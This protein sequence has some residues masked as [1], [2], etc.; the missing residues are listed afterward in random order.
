MPIKYLKDLNEIIAE[1]N[2]VDSIEDED[3]AIIANKVLEEFED[4]KR[5]RAEWDDKN[6]EALE[7]AKLVERPK[8]FPFENSA[9]VKYPLLT[10][11]A[12]QFA[13]RTYPEIIR[14]GRAIEY[15]VVGGDPQGDKAARAKRL[16]DHDNYQLLIASNR[17][18][19]ETD[20]LLH[21]LPIYGT[22]FRKTYFDP[23]DKTN[24]SELLLPDAIFINN[25]VPSLEKARRISHLLLVHKNDILEK[26]RMG[27][28]AD[29]GDDILNTHDDTDDDMHELIEQHRYLDLDYDGYEEPYI[30]VV[31]KNSNRVLRIVANWDPEDVVMS[32]EGEIVR[33]TR[34]DYFTDYHFIPSFDGTFYSLGFG[35]LLKPLNES[36]NTIINQLID[37]GTLANLQGGFIGKGLKMNKG[38]LRFRPGEWSPVDSFGQDIKSNIVPL[39]YKEP[40]GTLF[41]LLGLLIDATKELSSVTDA[42]TGTEHAQNTPATTILALVEQGMKVF[43]AIQRRLY[44]AFKKEFEKLYRLNRLFLDPEE[45]RII[46]D[47]PLADARADYEDLRL[48]VFPVADPNISSEAQRLAQAQAVMQ[49]VQ[50]PGV[51]VAAIL[52][53]YYEALQVPR[54]EELIIQPD[55]NA[56]PPPEVIDLQS[57]IQ[58]RGARLQLQDREVAIKE[59]ELQLNLVKLESEIA[60]LKAEAIKALA[61]AESKEAGVQLDKLKLNLEALTSQLDAIKLQHDEERSENESKQANDA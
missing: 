28:Y 21:M 48:D 23:I 17:W 29:I 20:K 40:S 37:A 55:P 32:S 26:I 4:D 54:R 39:Q 51:N 9:N 8:S 1:P 41:Q 52:D 14:N 31:H 58:E 10:S 42:L 53:R 25:S 11:A 13:A 50:I 30:V 15:K 18:E 47:D 43:S 49:T 45:Y 59:K 16:A 5:S 6:D 38:P 35:A 27:L 24:I 19:D 60:K 22:V 33:I 2:I 57:K 12:I 56:P 61:E 44:R 34:T 3:L 46:I 7:L 36:V